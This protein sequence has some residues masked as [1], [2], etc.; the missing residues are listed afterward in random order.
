MSKSVLVEENIATETLQ[1]L[2]VVEGGSSD[3]GVAPTTRFTK[4]L[5]PEWIGCLVGLCVLFVPMAMVMGT[6]N[7]I[8]TLMK[9]AYALLLDTCFYIMAIAVVCGALGSLFTEFGVVAMLNKLITPLMKPLFGLP[10]AA[11]VGAIA[12]FLS[13][14]PAI[15]TFIHNRG[16]MRYFK[17]YQIPAL[18][19]FGTCFG[20]GMIVVGAVLGLSGT[21]GVDTIVPAGIG[22]LCAI[23]GGVLSTRLLLIPCARKF[24]KEQDAVD[25]YEMDDDGVELPEGKRAIREGGVAMR[26]MSSLIDGGK[27][28]V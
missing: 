7:M 12:T 10:G 28:G 16:F 6:T 22:S 15:C 21:N 27:D 18:V 8:S 25:A 11:S 17:R 4:E 20:I 24:G 9:T 14:N 3:Q 19:N 13:D 1:N 26:A 5:G 2:S 23:L